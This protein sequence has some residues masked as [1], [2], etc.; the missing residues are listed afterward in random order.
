MM[1]PSPPITCAEFA[2]VPPICFLIKSPEAPMGGDPSR[3]I[4]VR[5]SPCNKLHP[6]LLSA[7]FL[8]TGLSVSVIL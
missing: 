5:N 3:N 8:M 1:S 6:K 2:F 7:V 4:L